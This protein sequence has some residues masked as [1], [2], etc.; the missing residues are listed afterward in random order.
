MPKRKC[1]L[2][3]KPEKSEKAKKP[4]VEEIPD[5]LAKWPSLSKV[6]FEPLQMKG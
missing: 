4:K 1:N 5:L 6:I 3:K 2:C